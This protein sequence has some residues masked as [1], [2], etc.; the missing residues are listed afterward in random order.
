MS[1]PTAKAV[2]NWP[3]PN[4]FY[5]IEV[6]ASGPFWPA[7]SLTLAQAQ[8]VADALFKHQQAIKEGVTIKP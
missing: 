1:K 8:A 4:Q 6:S 3:G 5:N 2:L 7:V